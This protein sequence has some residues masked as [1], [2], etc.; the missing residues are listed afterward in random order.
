MARKV[1]RALLFYNPAAHRLHPGCEHKLDFVASQF[2]ARNAVLDSVATE[3]PRHVLETGEDRASRGYDLIVACGGDGTINEV[4]NVAARLQLPLGILPGGT[5]NL[6]AAD[7]GIPDDLGRACENLFTGAPRSIKAGRADERLF[8][9]M[10][11]IGF[12]AAVCHRV[13][14]APKRRSGI[15]AYITAGLRTLPSYKFPTISL[16]CDGISFNGTQVI[17]SNIPRYGCSW[18]LAPTASSSGRGLDL[19]VLKAYS[20]FDYV[21]FLLRLASGHQGRPPEWTHYKG[22]TFALTSSEPVP[23]Q[24]DG[25]PHGTLPMD[26]EVVPKALEILVPKPP[27]PPKAPQPPTPAPTDRTSVP[28]SDLE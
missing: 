7:L 19:G 15:L 27:Q 28:P 26:F 25:E 14:A 13:S 21:Q 1:L 17:L 24:V 16:R 4:G 12:D 2:R 22:W 3:G 10:A 20:S 11:G 8:F 6:L 9:A 18:K 5:I 23:V